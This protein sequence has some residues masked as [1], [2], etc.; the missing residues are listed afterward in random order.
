M[1]NSPETQKPQT[2]M[3]TPQP[4][5]LGIL[6]PQGFP[7][8]PSSWVTDWSTFRSSDEKAQLFTFTHHQLPWEGKRALVVIH[9]MG[10]HGGRYLHLPHYMREYYDAIHTVDLQG[11]GRSEGIRGHIDRFDSLVDDVALAVVRFADQM[12]RRFGQTEVH[13]LGHSL[14]GH[15]V[16]RTL[17]NHSDLPIKAAI[18]SAPFLGIKAKVPVVKKYAA[19]GLSKVWGSV[20]LDTALDASA[21]SHDRSVVETYLKDRL[22]HSKMSPK[23]FTQVTAAMSDTLSLDNPRLPVPTLFMVPM[24]DSIVDPE[25]TRKFFDAASPEDSKT[26]IPYSNLY[27]EI[28][29][30]SEVDRN[31]VFAD[32]KAWLKSLGKAQIT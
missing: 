24:A 20:Q 23:F 15:L 13:L 25:M 3:N 2:T 6:Q 9:G 30:E 31:Q 7:G 5:Q 17:L 22:V 10:E 21:L 29:N 1:P 11:H 16:I 19:L 4:G 18:I 26:W 32:W 14:G 27:H 12:Q 28:L 8:L